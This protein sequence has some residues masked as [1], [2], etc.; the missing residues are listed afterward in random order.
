MNA[1]KIRETLLKAARVAGE[2]YV[3]VRGCDLEAA[4]TANDKPAK[5]AGS[6]RRK[7][8]TENPAASAK[9]GS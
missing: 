7:G 6:T 2:G 1:R 8:A 5:P 9:G 3:S 4:I